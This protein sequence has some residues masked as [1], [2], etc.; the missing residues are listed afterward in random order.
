MKKYFF[1][2]FK[3]FVLAEKEYFLCLVSTR[4]GDR[5]PVGLWLVTTGHKQMWFHERS[6]WSKHNDDDDD[7]DDDDGED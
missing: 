3:I 4:C 5:L 6:A 7:D 1:I 2:S